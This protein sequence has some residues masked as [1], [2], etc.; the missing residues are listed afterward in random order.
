MEAETS[1][2]KFPM[3]MVKRWSRKGHAPI[4]E[5]GPQQTSVGI[6]KE[7]GTDMIHSESSRKKSP[8]ERRKSSVDHPLV[9]A[10]RRKSSADHSLATYRS[11]S[12]G[13]ARRESI[14]TIRKS[15]VDNSRK[16]SVDTAC[17]VIYRPA[18][19]SAMRKTSRDLQ[20][21][22]ENVTNIITAQCDLSKN[23]A[24]TSF[25]QAGNTQGDSDKFSK[26]NK[27]AVELDR[28][29][30]AEG[31]PKE[32]IPNREDRE[33][34][35]E[36]DQRSER[37]LDRNQRRFQE[38]GDRLTVRD[39]RRKISGTSRSSV[40]SMD[41]DNHN[42]MAMSKRW[43]TLE[44]V[45]RCMFLFSVAFFIVGVLITVFGFS[46]TGI[47]HNQQIPLQVL[48]P[49]CLAMTVVMWVIGCVFS[50]LWNLEW[51]RQQH[52]FELRDRVQ[53]HALAMDILNNPVISPGMLQDPSLRRQ[54]LMKLRAQR[55]LD[56]R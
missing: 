43:T 11:S 12:P 5:T 55:T 2:D 44:T 23:T 51:K 52:A 31:V 54:L 17:T 21:A 38:Y 36:L 14:D 34:D 6:H 7:V 30:C 25:S 10:E 35:T 13:V 48:G 41:S 3:E 40:S 53:L 32:K 9:T 8:I 27:R 49:T 45:G 1:E 56:L 20:K 26:S 47:D 33:T 37:D 28:G 19:A 22:S 39:A 29:R 4:N 16:T 50:R 18:G 42:T 15:S 46:N 24:E